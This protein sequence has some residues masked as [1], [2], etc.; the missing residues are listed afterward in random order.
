MSNP[1]PKN[2]SPSKHPPPVTVS[3]QPLDEEP[4]L[5][6]RRKRWSHL[7]QKEARR[8]QRYAHPTIPD[9]WIEHISNSSPSPSKRNINR[10]VVVKKP[11]GES[12]PSLSSNP[13]VQHLRN[14]EIY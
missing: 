3:Q 7:T 14:T 9:R 6:L 10:R 13:N 11:G 12:L 8:K 5:A 1:L 2:L 4:M